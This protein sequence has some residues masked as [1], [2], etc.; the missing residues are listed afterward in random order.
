M[1][2]IGLIILRTAQFFRLGGKGN[3]T[4]SKLALVL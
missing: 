1:K 4:L 2:T 3:Q